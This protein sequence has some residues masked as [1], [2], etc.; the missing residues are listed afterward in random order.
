MYSVCMYLLHGL[1]FIMVQA[2]V[3]EH[4][5]FYYQQRSCCGGSLEYGAKSEE[6]LGRDRYV[7]D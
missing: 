2:L 1:A 6:A 7:D 3:D 4:C 5:Y